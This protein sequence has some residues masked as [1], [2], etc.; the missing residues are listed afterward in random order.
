[1]SHV[2]LFDSSVL[3]VIGDNFDVA[4]PEKSIL[5]KTEIEIVLSRTGPC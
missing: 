3:C 1:M 2:K 4:E 5:K